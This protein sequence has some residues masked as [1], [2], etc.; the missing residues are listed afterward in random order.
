MKRALI[1]GCNRGIG[2]AIMRKF[3]SEGY[4]ITTVT[5]KSPEDFIAECGNLEKQYGVHIH[6]MLCDFSDSQQ[7]A[8][9]VK[10]L[11]E[12]G[13]PIDVLVNNAGIGEIKPLFYIEY[14][15]LVSSFGVN[16]FAPVM[17]SKAVS[18]NMMRQ[19]SGAIV[20]ISSMGSLGH[21]PAG[22]LYDASKAALNQFTVSAAQELA[23]FGIRVN[24]VACG[25]VDTGL[26]SS[27]S[28]SVQ[29]KLT[30]ATAMKR[31]AQDTEIAET[32]FFL[33]SEKASYITGQIVRADGGAII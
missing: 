30:K 22:H 12:F 1:T 27:F 7:L 26:F 14:A 33:A 29:K 32:V 3:A 23:P 15:D 4:D 8:N 5:R 19:G 9:V 16:Y 25:P 6:N 24:A 2:A 10:E 20:N 31:A 17:I 18:T 13:E 11:E 21:Q 28:D